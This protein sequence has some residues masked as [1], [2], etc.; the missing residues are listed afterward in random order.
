MKEELRR[1]QLGQHEWIPRSIMM[2]VL[3]LAADLH[4]R[5][6]TVSAVGW[7]RLLGSLRSP[8]N[9]VIF[10]LS[11]TPVTVIRGPG[12]VTER[13]LPSVTAHAGAASYDPAG[14]RIQPT[15][16]AE[17]LTR[18]GT[19]RRGRG[20]GLTTGTGYFHEALRTFFRDN[21]RSMTPSAWVDALL[22]HL[23]DIMYTGDV[24]G[25]PPDVLAE[26]IGV[27][28]TL[29][30][31]VASGDLTVGEFAEYAAARWREIQQDFRDAK[32]GLPQ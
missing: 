6:D 20:G 10:R 17:G 13:Q 15:F 30:S 23:P 5:G 12:D 11:L 9:A 14:E 8:T 26:P 19:L 24:T 2:Q 3:E 1:V 27:F 4:S 7:V 31:G 22:A 25:L 21:A 32:Q 29:P 18:D 28:V 16:R